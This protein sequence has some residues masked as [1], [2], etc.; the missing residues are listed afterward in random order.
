MKPER[1]DGRKRLLHRNLL[2]PCVFLPLTPEP[3]VK[4]PTKRVRKRERSTTEPIHILEQSESDIDEPHDV[5]IYV[6]LESG[7]RDE[8]ENDALEENRVSD[9][10]ESDSSSDNERSEIPAAV[11]TQEP[12]LDELLDG[13]VQS[14][15]QVQVDEPPPLP[16]TRRSTP[17]R[18]APNPLTY[19]QLGNP[20]RF[21]SSVKATST[22]QPTNQMPWFPPPPPGLS[23]PASVV[24]PP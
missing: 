11:N 5:V 12:N 20:E 22:F 15:E 10:N 21:V 6:S 23:T 14:E 19:N 13:Q 7:N 16:S 24:Q 8:P 3:Q 1:K 18:S 2:L 17:V 9:Q 4:S